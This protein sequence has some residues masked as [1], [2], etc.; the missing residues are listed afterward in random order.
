MHEHI[1]LSIR[2]FSLNINYMK[3]KKIYILIFT[4][5]VFVILGGFFA[6]AFIY[7]PS[8]EVEL[9]DEVAQEFLSGNIEIEDIE[10]LP[11]EDTTE[12]TPDPIVASMRISIPRIGVDAKVGEVGLTSTGK[13]AS[14]KIFSDVGW[15]KY[16]T[17]PGE[18]GSAVLAG[19]VNN[20][21]SLPAV[22]AKLDQLNVGDDI[23]LTNADGVKMHFK[24]TGE[25]SYPYDAAPPEVFLEADGKYLKLITCTGT[26]MKDRRTHSERLVI[27][28]ELVEA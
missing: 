16:G 12:S 6:R 25:N 3:Q 15:Y 8:D 24:V 26:W 21:A 11:E 18:T 9:S 13:M 4:V 28:A 22:F 19:H 5:I 20:G 23:Y 27:K 10:S 1:A 17:A 14:P 2:P 7:Y